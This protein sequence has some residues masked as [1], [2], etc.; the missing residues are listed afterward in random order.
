M[1]ISVAF[2]GLK[3]A[4]PNVKILHQ[5]RLFAIDLSKQTSKADNSFIGGRFENPNQ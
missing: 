3:L 5:T 1:I 2:F 4:Y